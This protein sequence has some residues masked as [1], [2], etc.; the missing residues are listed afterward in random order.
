[1]ARE[2][3]SELLVR[4]DERVTEILRRLGEQDDKLS[5]VNIRINDVYTNLDSRVT[6]LENFRWYML[7]AAA[8]VGMAIAVVKDWWLNKR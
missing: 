8:I 4:I 3:D 7:G 2:K 5:N 1:M 6:T